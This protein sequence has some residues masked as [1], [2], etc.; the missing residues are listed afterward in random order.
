MNELPSFMNNRLNSNSSCL[1]SLVFLVISLPFVSCT[2][3]T[4]QQGAD[5]ENDKFKNT[6]HRKPPG[7][8][9]DTISIDFPAA[10][11]YIPDSIQLEKIKAIT[12]TMGFQSITHDCYYQMK[13]SRNVLKKNWPNIKIVE[14]RN[15]RYIFFMQAGG[16]KE[17]IDLDSQNDPCGVF[18]FDGNKQAL[19]ADMMNIDSELGFY[20]TK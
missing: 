1:I 14:I 6:I 3:S 8:F 2:N 12:D 10:V 19:L 5:E 18:I 16:G 11:F 15:A 9:T 4:R 13:N 7:S 20:F 17:I